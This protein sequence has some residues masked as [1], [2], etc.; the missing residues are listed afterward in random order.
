[1]TCMF[2]RYVYVFCE[3]AEKNAKGGWDFEVK[4]Y[5]PVNFLL[6][7]IAVRLTKSKASWDLYVKEGNIQTKVT[8]YVCKDNKKIR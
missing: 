4:P 3:K 7:D 6:Q 5:K 1:M 8:I 2:Y